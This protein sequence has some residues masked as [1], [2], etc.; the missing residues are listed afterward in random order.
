LAVTNISEECAA[1]ICR[2]ERSVV[3]KVERKAEWVMKNKEW[4]VRD[5]E[6]SK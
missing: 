5:G 3:K 6:E 1:C 2:I 4:P